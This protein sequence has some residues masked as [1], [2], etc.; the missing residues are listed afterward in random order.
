[1]KGPLHSGKLKPERRG[2]DE[3]WKAHKLPRRFPKKLHIK[4]P[5]KEGI[6]V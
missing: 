1:M 5:E 2:T 6:L 3:V 4:E